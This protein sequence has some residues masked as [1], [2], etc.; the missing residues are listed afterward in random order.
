VLVV[1][2]DPELL[3][4]MADVLEADGYSVVALSDGH[5]AL[6]YLRDHPAPALLIA[7]LMMPGLTAAELLR[8]IDATLDLDGTMAVAVFTAA[9]DSYITASGIDPALV[10]RK[11]DLPKLLQRLVAAVQRRRSR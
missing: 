8:Q 5:E 11:P 4:V 7:D 3:V 9:S 6:E 1:D 2:D 10:V